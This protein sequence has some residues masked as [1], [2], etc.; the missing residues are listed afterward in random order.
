MPV[1]PRTAQSIRS[2]QA[3]AV[4]YRY[5]DD[6]LRDF[7]KWILPYHSEKRLDK[8]PQTWT[9][10]SPPC[11]RKLSRTRRSTTGL[12]SIASCERGTA[13][14]DHH[15]EPLDS[16][17]G[18]QG[19]LSSERHFH[20]R[21]GPASPKPFRNHSHFPH[22]SAREGPDKAL[23]EFAPLTGT[24]LEAAARRRY[25]SASRCLARNQGLSSLPYFLLLRRRPPS[26]AP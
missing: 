21:K 25:L 14:G 15:T 8:T 22:R 9:R 23:W 26:E 16:G 7:K 20:A 19:R 6:A 4:S 18:I 24:L 13:A 17:Q 11:T 2:K 3:P 12:R 10:S 5:S 1:P